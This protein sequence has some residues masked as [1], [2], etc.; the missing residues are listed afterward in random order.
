MNQDQRVMSLLA[1]R[2]PLTLLLDLAAPP[3]ANEVYSTEGGNADWL[4]AFNGAA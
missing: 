1:A 2:V 3:R 4:L